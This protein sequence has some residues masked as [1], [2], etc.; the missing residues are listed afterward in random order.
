M[1][2][3][4]T[5]GRFGE[6]TMELLRALAWA[7]ARSRPRHLQRAALYAFERRW[8]RMLAVSAASA[9]AVSLLHDGSA[10]PTGLADGEAPWLL[11]LLGEARH[12]LHEGRNPGS[13]DG[14]AAA[15]GD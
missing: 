14:A 1:A 3:I 8:A 10:V 4:E 15:R 2:G 13:W 5:G 6:D 11:D 7:K 12:D 9:F